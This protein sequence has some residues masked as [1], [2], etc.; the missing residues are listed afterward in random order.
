ME[1]IVL[2]EFHTRGKFYVT[3]SVF[4]CQYHSIIAASFILILLQSEGQAG[5][6]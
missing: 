3:T 1:C 6:S 2:G 5:E 4:L